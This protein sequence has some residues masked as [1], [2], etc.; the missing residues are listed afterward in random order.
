LEVSIKINFSEIKQA[1]I[2]KEMVGAAL[3]LCSKAGSYITGADLKATGGEH[4]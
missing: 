2:P 3:I 4:L 1:G